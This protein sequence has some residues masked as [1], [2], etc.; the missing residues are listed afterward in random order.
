[1]SA[2]PQLVIK[3]DRD[4]RAGELRAS[5]AYLSCSEVSAGTPG[6]RSVRLEDEQGTPT[7]TAF[8]SFSYQSRLPQSPLSLE[9]REALVE[10]RD[11]RIRGADRIALKHQSIKNTKMQ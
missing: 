6:L 3:R 5:R 2:A 9:G 7:Y 4:R 8:F 1:M 10:L 11:L